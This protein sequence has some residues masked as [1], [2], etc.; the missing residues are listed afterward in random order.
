MSKYCSVSKRTAQLLSALGPLHFISFL[1]MKSE[2]ETKKLVQKWK[3]RHKYCYKFCSSA[4]KIRS[5]DQR[6]L[7]LYITQMNKAIYFHPGAGRPVNSQLLIRLT[8]NNRIHIFQ[9]RSSK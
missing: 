3:K 8:I 6:C 2:I 7:L 9:H 4:I 5:I 1:K